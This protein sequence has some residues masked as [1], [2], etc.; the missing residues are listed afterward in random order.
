MSKAPKRRRQELD[1]NQQKQKGLIF[2]GASKVGIKT[3]SARGRALGAGP[4]LLAT[5]HI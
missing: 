5:G 2:W 4:G 3:I 1:G